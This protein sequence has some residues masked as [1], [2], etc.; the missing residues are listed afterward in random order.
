MIYRLEPDKLNQDA[1]EP[2]IEVVRERP[3]S[4]VLIVGGGSLLEPYRERIRREGLS[5][6]FEFTGYVPYESL[7]GIYERLSVFVAPVWQESFGQV[8]SF[9]MS[10]G[11]PVVGYDV[12][13]IPEIVD[14]PA[15]VAPAGNPAALARIIVDLLDHPEARAA[16]AARQQQRVHALYS[17]ESMVSRYADIY[18]TLVEAPR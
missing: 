11:V 16:I 6:H 5:E 12:G 13:A 8:S 3:G 18:S 9:A 1:I 15:L 7:P 10:M 4:R 14:D 17:V 2:F